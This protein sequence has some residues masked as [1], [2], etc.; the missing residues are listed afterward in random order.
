MEPVQGIVFV[1]VALAIFGPG[2][3][4]LTLAWHRRVDPSLLKLTQRLSPVW[5]LP[6]YPAFLFVFAWVVGM[7][8]AAEVC[9]P[10]VFFGVIVAS[11]LGFRRAVME[12]SA[13][14]ST[15]RIGGVSNRNRRAVAIVL[16]L[17]C[18]GIAGTAIVAGVIRSRLVAPFPLTGDPVVV[19]HIYSMGGDDP[20]PPEN[21]PRLRDWP[22]IGEPVR[23]TPEVAAEIRQILNSRS[24]YD[25]GQPACFEPGM[26]IS[27]GDGGG[28]VDVVICLLCHRA[29]FYRGDSQVARKISDE[30][31]KRLT[32]IYRRLFNSRPPQP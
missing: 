20:F 17:G 18:L 6:I 22:V 4:W 14:S 31:N 25:V 2:A 27:F 9:L 12:R 1:I 26:A 29:V 19:R 23:V 13:D 7:D 16:A 15:P 21:S 30:G 10:I 11:Y 32:S 8:R 3:Y 28:R 24:T 5:T